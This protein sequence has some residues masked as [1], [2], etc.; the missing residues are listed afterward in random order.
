LAAIIHLKID[1][2]EFELCFK[3]QDGG[4]N[5]FKMIVI[6]GIV[7]KKSKNLILSKSFAWQPS[8]KVFQKFT[9]QI[10]NQLSRRKKA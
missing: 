2:N 8:E 6:A 4:A 3:I 7:A 9:N 5:R 10:E 1:W